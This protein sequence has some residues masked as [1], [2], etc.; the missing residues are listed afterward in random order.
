VPPGNA[1]ALAI[2]VCRVVFDEELHARLSANAARVART[3]FHSDILAARMRRR[4]AEV[5][6]GEK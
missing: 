4:L 1:G 2:A 5:V 6:D 3:A